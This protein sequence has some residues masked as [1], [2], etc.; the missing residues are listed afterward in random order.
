MVLEIP[1]GLFNQSDVR[2]TPI[3]TAT[4]TAVGLTDPTYLTLSLDADL[5]GE[6]VLTAGGTM[7]FTDTGANGT[8]TIDL[9]S[10]TRYYSVNPSAWIPRNPDIDNVSIN[11]V[12]AGADEDAVSFTAAINLP[13][14]AVVTACVVYGNASAVAG[15]SWELTRLTTNAQTVALMATASI[16]TEDATIDNATIDNQTYNYCLES[17]TLDTGDELWGARITYTIDQLT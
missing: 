6:R 13:H 1:G 8:L 9:K 5:T 12:E 3:S 7:D 15:E 2:E 11:E 14:G 10:V 17:S 16:G 4:A